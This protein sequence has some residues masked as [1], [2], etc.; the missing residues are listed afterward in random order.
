MPVN[1]RKI[2]FHRFGKGKPRH[3]TEKA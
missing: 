3:A 1:R 2:I